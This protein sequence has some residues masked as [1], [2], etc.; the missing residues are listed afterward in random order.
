MRG[1]LI[2]RVDAYEGHIV[3]EVSV[4]QHGAHQALGVYMWRADDSGA[5]RMVG[6]VAEWE[7]R[8]ERQRRVS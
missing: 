6:T 4:R 2:Y 7:A 8:S 5:R 3:L 1:S